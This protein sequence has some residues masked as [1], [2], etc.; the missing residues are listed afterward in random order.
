MIYLLLFNGTEILE[1]VIPPPDPPQ[2][3]P[4]EVRAALKSGQ[5]TLYN[6]TTCT[7]VHIKPLHYSVIYLLFQ[8]VDSISWQLYISTLIHCNLTECNAQ[9][10]RLKVGQRWSIDPLANY[11]PH[12]LLPSCTVAALYHHHPR[13]CRGP[14][15]QDL[16]DVNEDDNWFTFHVSGWKLLEVVKV[17]KSGEEEL[18]DSFHWQKKSS[19][20]PLVKMHETTWSLKYFFRYECVDAS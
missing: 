14:S 10:W 9:R 3:T 12:T 19:L 13:D 5:R 8:I 17:E 15:G 20:W 2:N 7:I 1:Y 6:R 18:I 4:S 11:R 16:T